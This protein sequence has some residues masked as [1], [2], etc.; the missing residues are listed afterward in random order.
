MAEIQPQQ[1]K[2]ASNEKGIVPD[3]TIQ[4]PKNFLRFKDV[5]HFHF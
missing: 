5:L 3:Y 1:M 2:W 4:C